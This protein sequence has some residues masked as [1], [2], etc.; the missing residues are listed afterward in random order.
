MIKEIT[1]AIIGHFN[2][3]IVLSEEVMDYLESVSEGRSLLYLN[4][5]DES[6]KDSFHSLLFSPDRKFQEKIEAIIGC[7]VIDNEGIVNLLSSIGKIKTEFSYK[8]DEITVP[9][10]SYFFELFIKRLK[11]TN[12]IIKDLNIKDISPKEAVLIRNSTL[13]SSKKSIAFFSKLFENR[14]F[15]SNDFYETLKLS[16]KVLTEN[17]KDNDLKKSFIEK[18]LFYSG[19]IQK[20][21]NFRE[22][23]KKNNMETLMMQGISTPCVDINEAFNNIKIINQINSV[24]FNH[25]NTSDHELNHM[26][27]NFSGDISDIFDLFKI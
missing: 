25:R 11:L 17:Y 15:F 6:D 7:E 12:T 27:I 16:L 21:L 13:K 2:N 3:G 23:L 26:D 19:S 1:G 20:E 8:N 9:Y 14:L 22:L 4:K 18:K 24:I 5:I 10:E